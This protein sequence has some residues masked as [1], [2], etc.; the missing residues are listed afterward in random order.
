[1]ATLGSRPSGDAG[2]DGPAAGRA[3]DSPAGIAPDG[4]DG[5][6]A[7]AGR[8]SSD[9]GSDDGGSDVPWAGIGLLVTVLVTGAFAAGWH[10]GRRWGRLMG[11]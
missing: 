5:V 1:M 8:A 9:D 4:S 2:P 11:W 10:F 6:E 3:P 7:Y